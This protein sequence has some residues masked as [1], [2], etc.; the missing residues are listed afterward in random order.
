MCIVDSN[1]TCTINGAQAPAP[2]K[3]PGGPH[4]RSSLQTMS[5]AGLD[6]TELLGDIETKVEKHFPGALPSQ[7]ILDKVSVTIEAR[8]LTPE[9]TLY[10]QSVCPDEIN[11]EPGDITNLFTEYLGEVFHLGGLGG[12]PFTGKTGFGAYSHHVP[13]GG[14]CFILLAPHIGLDSG[15]NFGMY[16]REG[17]A[18]AGAACGAAIGALGYCKACKPLPDL[19]TAQD[20]YQMSY[21]IHKVHQCKHEILAETTDNAVQARLA[22][23]MHKVATEML[24]KIVSLDFGGPE[25]T[26]TILTGV[27]I[28]MP[29]PME[30]Y[31]Q[32][33]EFYVKEKNGGDTV[34]LFEQTFGTRSDHQKNNNTWTTYKDDDGTVFVEC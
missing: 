28:N 7:G 3:A 25:S 19:T 24:D 34:D 6:T 29:E 21:I 16:D 20:D 22:H 1:P 27:Q 15:C 31:F 30:D 9:N 18:S 17:Q 10:A 32:P 4:R 23:H 26:L 13:E 14:H 33:L 2:V 8:G 12:I 5:L 11:H